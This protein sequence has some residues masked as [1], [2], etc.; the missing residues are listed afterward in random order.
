MEFHWR[1]YPKDDIKWELMS[2]LKQNKLDLQDQKQLSYFWQKQ[3][4]QRDPTVTELTDH[5]IISNHPFNSMR[6]GDPCV[7]P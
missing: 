7:R 2:N 6:P 1:D 4:P 5:V 3:F